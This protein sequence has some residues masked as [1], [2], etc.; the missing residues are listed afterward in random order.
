MYVGLYKHGSA[1]MRI[2]SKSEVKSRGRARMA[3]L[4]EQ[5]EKSR[6]ARQG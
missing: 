2:M 5:Y 3:N 1:R 6:R 4:A